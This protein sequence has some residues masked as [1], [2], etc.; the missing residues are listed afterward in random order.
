MVLF[1]TK[2]SGQQ[3]ET[4]KHGETVAGGGHI[5]INYTDTYI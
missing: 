2:E 1:K 3:K 4:T 5:G